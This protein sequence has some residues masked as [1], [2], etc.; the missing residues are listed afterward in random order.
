MLFRSAQVLARA[1]GAEHRG[2]RAPTWR[3]A[4]AVRPQAFA[5]CRQVHLSVGAHFGL[6]GAVEVVQLA[7]GLRV[8]VAWDDPRAD[9]VLAYLET[10]SAPAL[11]HTVT[12]AKGQLGSAADLLTRGWAALGV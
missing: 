3:S 12:Y 8:L 6:A 4:L 5:R 11:Y 1:K 9:D 7:L 10:A 2:L